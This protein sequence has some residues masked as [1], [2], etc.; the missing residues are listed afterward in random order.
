MSIHVFICEENI[1]FTGKEN[2]SRRGAFPQEKI[3]KRAYL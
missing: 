1:G 3:L 2:D